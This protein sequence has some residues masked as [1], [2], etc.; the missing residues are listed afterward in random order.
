MDKINHEN[1]APIHQNPEEILR[2]LSQKE[3]RIFHFVNNIEKII[4]STEIKEKNAI[5]EL[6][7]LFQNSF[8]ET[9]KNGTII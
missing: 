3:N 7:D 8:K 1:S 6:I 9:K 2:L 5:T 4:S